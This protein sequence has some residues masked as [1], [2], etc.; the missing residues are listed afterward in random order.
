MD[1]LFW[2]WKLCR[3]GPPIFVN[4]FLVLTN[5]L[6]LTSANFRLRIVTKTM[7]DWSFMMCMNFF[8]FIRMVLHTIS[9][10]NWNVYLRIYCICLFFPFPSFM[11]PAS[12]IRNKSLSVIFC[13]YYNRFVYLYFPFSKWLSL[14]NRSGPSTFWF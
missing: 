6:Y 9:S 4:M 3:K 7:N 1:L 5:T 8:I 2:H 12:N 14:C 13:F 10:I 11:F